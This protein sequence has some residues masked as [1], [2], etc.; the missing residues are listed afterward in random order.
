M[1]IVRMNLPGIAAI[2]LSTLMLTSC[3][4]TESTRPGWQ[5]SSSEYRAAR[6]A[7]ENRI[8]EKI[9]AG[10]RRVDRVE[11]ERA[12]A[13]HSGGERI[14]V[15][16]EGRFRHRDKGWQPFEFN[17]SYDTYDDQIT[18]ASYRKR[19]SGSGGSG[20]F[21]NERPRDTR[22][23][24]NACRYA[25]HERVR[26]KNPNARD[27]HWRENTLQVRRV[28]RNRTRYSGKGGFVGGKG[29]KRAF[30]FQCT[31]DFVDRRVIQ[32]KAH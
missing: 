23:S 2:A 25:V 10:R 21:D 28:N 11:F 15:R 7:C 27:I 14:K 12:D 8:R 17:C 18:N 1:K 16:G 3:V 29:K 24:R 31:Y 20:D 30:D 13:W 19:Y 5:E 9:Y 6:H 4:E 26:R 22:E 32:A